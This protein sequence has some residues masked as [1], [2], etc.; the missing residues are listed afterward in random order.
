M[1][2]DLATSPPPAVR[3]WS[4]AHACRARAHPVDQAQRGRSTAAVLAAIGRRFAPG[5]HRR[6]AS[7]D[8]GR[9]GPGDVRNSASTSSSGGERSAD[10]RPQSQMIPLH[11]VQAY[12][13]TQESRGV[14]TTCKPACRLARSGVLPGVRALVRGCMPLGGSSNGRTS[15]FGP[16]NR[17]SSPCPPACRP[18]ARVAAPCACAR[19]AALAE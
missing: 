5:R 12:L 18:C 2:L 9:S 10:V 3:G 4:A 16:E 15:G 19:L 6:R 7:P 14:T 17:G 13:Q 1:S 11:G 8:A